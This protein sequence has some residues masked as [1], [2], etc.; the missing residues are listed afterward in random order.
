VTGI[1][2]LWQTGGGGPADCFWCGGHAQE[3]CAACAAQM[4][5]GVTLIEA[6]PETRT[7]T[8]RWAVITDESVE[9]LFQPESL[10]QQV[11]QSR[12]ALIE[13]SAFGGLFGA[14]LF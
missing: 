2:V 6:S 12:K 13:P 11:L 10:V 1:K 9:V 14:V 3:P 5:T 8:G 4:A 7:P